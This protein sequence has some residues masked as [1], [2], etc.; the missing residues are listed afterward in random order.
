MGSLG[1][2]PFLELVGFEKDA[3]GDTMKLDRSKVDRILL[4][5][6][7]SELNSALT[8]PFFGVL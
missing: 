8:N 3:T 2:I 5:A 1:G 6:A 7:G 4:D